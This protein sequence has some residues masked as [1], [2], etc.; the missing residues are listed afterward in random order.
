MVT[1]SCSFVNTYV[2]FKVNTDIV[3][4]TLYPYPL[5]GMEMNTKYEDALRQGCSRNPR[6]T[7]VSNRIMV[8][9]SV[10]VALNRYYIP[11]N[12]SADSSH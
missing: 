12:A 3:T 8:L 1:R 9:M 5:V 10:F 7:R 4:I 6:L 11:A 2:A